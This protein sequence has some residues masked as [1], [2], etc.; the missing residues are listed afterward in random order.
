VEE[1]EDEDDDQHDESAIFADLKAL[2]WVAANKKGCGTVRANLWK[3]DKKSAMPNFWP[4][5][6][7]KGIASLPLFPQLQQPL[8]LCP[9]LLCEFAFLFF[10]LINTDF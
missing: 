2:D 9:L 3:R 8:S 4:A 7:D 1:E 6:Q 10:Y 5:A